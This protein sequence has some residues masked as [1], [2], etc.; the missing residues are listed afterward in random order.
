[1]LKPTQSRIL[2]V[3]RT[4]MTPLPLVSVNLATV[5]IESVFYGIFV[6]LSGLYTYFHCNRITFKR[7]GDLGGIPKYFTPVFCGSMLVS[8]T[9]TGHWVVTVYRLFEAFVRFKNGAEPA[10]YYADLSVTTEAIKTSFCIATFMICDVLLI[11]RLWIVWAYN[12]YII[13][14][15]CCSLLGLC[16]AGPGVVYSLTQVQTGNSVFIASVARWISADYSFIFATNIY[17][18][19]GIA[20]RVWRGRQKV[21]YHGGGNLNNVLVTVVES[22]T[23]FALSSTYITFFFVSYEASS[24]IQYIAIDTVSAIAGISLMMI[25]VRVGLGWAQ[26]APLLTPPSNAS[27]GTLQCPYALRPMTIDIAMS[28]DT[29]EDESVEV[30]YAA[31][32][33]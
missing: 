11:Y 13:I 1:M 15:P 7:G 19:C 8:G 3:Q 21:T 4:G 22:A 24:N 16:V 9:I 25:N 10:L 26:Q 33:V 18:T 14:L 12:N 28:V 30:S 5:A 31:S 27:R 6:L 2:G 29:E 17:C 20:W 32:N 23:L